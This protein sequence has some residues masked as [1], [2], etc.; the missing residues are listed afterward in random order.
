M[1]RVKLG[2]LIAVLGL[3]LTVAGA[4]FLTARNAVSAPSLTDVPTTSSANVLAGPRIVFR[5]SVLGQDYS[6]IAL[7]A[8]ADP[9]GPRAVLPLSCERVYSAVKA[10]VCVTAERGVTPSYGLAVLNAELQPI[11]SSRL[12]GLPSRA[13][14]SADGT[15]VATTTFVTGHSYAQ[16]SFSTET[17]IRGGGVEPRNLETFTTTLP[18]GQVLKAANRN[19]W[20]VTFAA[21]N[22]T[23]YVTVASGATTWLARGSIQRGTMTALRTDAECPSLSPDG[24]K[25]AYKKRLG[26]RKAGVWRLAVLDLAT[27]TETLVAES[28]SVDDQVEWLDDDHLLYT[29]PRPGSEA[30]I[31]D[32][33]SVPS[34]GVGTPTVLI[35]HASS[36]AVVRP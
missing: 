16:T 14:M 13:R 19:Y 2:M 11:R 7:V 24:S 10:G 21:D 33:W 17:I 35:T 36:P 22:D 9:G 1:T 32:I 15:L 28:A 23:F 12:V 26:N 30:T 25:V 3:C 6:K 27:N 8:L 31:S 5:N 29:R 20:G 34:T 4:Y 18:N